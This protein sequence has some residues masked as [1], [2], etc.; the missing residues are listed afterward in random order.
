MSMIVLAA[1]LV[2]GGIFFYRWRL[3]R[4]GPNLGDI[5]P[6][7]ELPTSRDTDELGLVGGHQEDT[8]RGV[9]H[10]SSWAAFNPNPTDAGP[11]SFYYGDDKSDLDRRHSETDLTQAMPLPPPPAAAAYK[12][13]RR[14]ADQNGVSPPES[15][16]L[17]QMQGA[18]GDDVPQVQVTSASAGQ[19]QPMGRFPPGQGYRQSLDQ[20]EGTESTEGTWRTW[21]VDQNQATHERTWKDRYMR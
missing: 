6:E 3:R 16:V 15:P 20:T 8:Q 10:Y 17:F 2:A 4:K 11:T 9:H 18:A 13:Y 19:G 12:P 14:E 7:K 5:P 1:L 21:G